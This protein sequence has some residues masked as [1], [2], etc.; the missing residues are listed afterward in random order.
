M[1]P[2]G[3]ASR[4]RAAGQATHRGQDLELALCG[5]RSTPRWHKVSAASWSSRHHAAAKRCCLTAIE[6]SFHSIV[7]QPP[8]TH[9]VQPM[10]RL[11]ALRLAR[12]E[13]AQQHIARAGTGWQAHLSQPERRQAQCSRSCPRPRVLL[14]ISHPLD[15]SEL[16]D[17]Q[18]L[19]L[20]CP[21]EP[22]LPS[23]IPTLSA[24]RRM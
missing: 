2:G 8:A 5:Q 3:P 14:A 7:S 21:S 17:L 16:A 18:P 1:G 4:R 15:D 12:C 6:S 19:S 10:V 20:I 23:W 22:G 24:L 9:R 11:H 13:H